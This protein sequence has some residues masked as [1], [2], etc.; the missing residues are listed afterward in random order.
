MKSTLFTLLLALLYQL[1]GAQP[2]EI[3]DMQSGANIELQAGTPFM[4]TIWSYPPA[5]NYTLLSPN[6][7]VRDNVVA[8]YLPR[9]YISRVYRFY[10]LVSGFNSNITIFYEQSK[11]VSLHENALYQL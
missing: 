7:L 9:P 4:P 11:V 8:N 3:I 2:F 1:V 6:T 10:N 5:T